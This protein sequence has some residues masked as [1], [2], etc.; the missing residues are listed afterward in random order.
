MVTPTA[1]SEPSQFGVF[2]G[3]SRGDSKIGLWAVR[4]GLDH[5]PRASPARSVHFGR[6]ARAGGHGHPPGPSQRIRGQSLFLYN[7]T[8]YVEWPSQKFNSLND[9]IVICILGQNPF[10]SA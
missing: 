1:L 4:S 2:T 8:R 9:P 3:R 7:F 10:G 5:L 6:D